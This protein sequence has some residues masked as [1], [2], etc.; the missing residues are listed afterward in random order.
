MSTLLIL[1]FLL[2]ACFLATF[3]QKKSHLL[4]NLFTLAI[5][6]II[7]GGWFAAFLL[8]NLETYP[9][10][11]NPDWQKRNAIV[12]LG[13][14]A[15]K[16]PQYEVI[17][18]TVLAYSRIH[19]AANLYFSCKKGKRVCSVVI[20]GG[21]ALATSKAEALVYKDELL[22]LGINT[23]DLIAESE[24]MNTFKNAEYT[25]AILKKG[26]YDRV[27][28][29]TSG[30]HEKRALLYFSNFG[31]SAIPA[32]SDYIAAK[33]TFIPLGYNFAITDFALHEYIGIMRFYLYNLLGWN[34][35]VSSVG[36]P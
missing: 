4:A 3:Q 7:G 14:G 23:S 22:K 26:Q 27:F 13:G 8:K 2:I 10:L 16:L 17:K 11:K 19:E 18:P 31:I 28:M 12:V 35:T 29:V 30:I 15:I 20:S 21:D 24:S 9:P 1:L 5:F 6:L 36:A 32:P 33:T 25:S 34:K